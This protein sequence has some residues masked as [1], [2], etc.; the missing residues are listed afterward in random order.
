MTWYPI[1]S[2]C[3]CSLEIEPDFM[4]RKLGKHVMDMRNS[5]APDGFALP[6]AMFALVVVAV[7]STG[8]F[9]LA[10]QETRIGLASK[11]ARAAFY[12]AERGAMEVMS[13]WDMATF[14]SLP[15]WGSATVTDSTEDGSWSVT[16]TRMSNRMYFLTSAGGL[17]QGSE[18]LGAAGRTLGFVARLNALELEAPAAFTARDRVRFVGKAT[19]RGV[20]ENPPSWPSDV[21]PGPLED[22]A[23]MLTDRLSNLDYKPKNFAVSGNPPIMEDDALIDQLFQVFG[24]LSWDELTSMAT[25]TVSP[26]NFNQIGPSLTSGGTCDRS[27]AQ[28]WG[29][30]ENP[31]APCGSFFP[32]IHVRGPGTSKIN[33]GGSGQGILL[34]DGDLWAGGNFVF[35]GLII[36]KG[37]FETGGN[38]NRV[39]GAVMAGNADLEE[40][41]LT[42]GSLLQ[43]SSCAL[44][45]AV[46][47][48]PNLTWVKP[49]DRRSWVD[50]SSLIGG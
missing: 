30:P 33:G 14:G 47:N 44:S 28:N 25:H 42:G 15:T 3:G 11:R 21:C 41:D 4:N 39:N 43:Y 5:L 8:G 1:P 7:L 24:D 48:N 10:R 16:V 18:V 32:M 22:K 29:D 26:R 50:L 37:K 34:V 19:V 9:Y 2:S 12:S 49:I 38:G 17:S 35:Y 40:Q 6:A 46:E 23:G 20:D 13:E 27:N 36:V 45:R 31:G